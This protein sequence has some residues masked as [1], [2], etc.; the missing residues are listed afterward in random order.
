[1]RPP[2]S[3]EAFL[4]LTATPSTSSGR[5]AP[6]PVA[7]QETLADPVPL[8]LMTGQR[9]GFDRILTEQGLSQVS[10]FCILQDNQGF[11]WF[12]MEH[13]LNRYDGY[14]F[15]V[16]KH[17]PEDP[18]SLSDSWISSMIVDRSS[19]DLWIGTANAGLNRFDLG[20]NQITRYQ[21]DPDDIRSLSNDRVLS[22]VQ[23]RAGDLWVGTEYGLN[24][25][26][27]ETESFVLYR[28]D[29]GNPSSLSGNSVRAITQDQ[30]G[31]LWI[32]T[33]DGLNK[34]EPGSERLTRYIKGPNG[35][36]G[37]ISNE[38]WNWLARQPMGKKP[39]SCVNNSCRT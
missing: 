18:N 36:P 24:R 11:M 34:L 29:P 9:L 35:S 32:G 25:L 16:H 33:D 21:N 27:R 6:A 2:L 28:H 10:V 31:H 17:D 7:G 3:S 13:G 30:D 39:C 26:E 4:Q 37:L 12:G 8:P 23:D 19:G 38:I 14:T 1:L 15:A 20:V 5:T 22:M